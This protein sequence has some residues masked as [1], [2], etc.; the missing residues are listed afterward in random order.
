MQWVYVS[1][2]LEVF[3]MTEKNT[4]IDHA[5][6]EELGLSQKRPGPLGLQRKTLFILYWYILLPSIN[7]TFSEMWTLLNLQLK[8]WHVMSCLRFSP[9]HARVLTSRLWHSN[10]FSPNIS[11][12]RS[13]RIRSLCQKNRYKVVPRIWWLL[14]V[15]FM[16]FW[17]SWMAISMMCIY[18]C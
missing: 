18:G 15:H 7:Q 3:P 8:P 2:L 12:K 13:E 17:S 11:R 1:W 5:P 10:Y 4:R 16:S 6:T 14:M 9:K